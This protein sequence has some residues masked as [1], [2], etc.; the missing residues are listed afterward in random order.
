[1]GAV[2]QRAQPSRRPSP[3]ESRRPGSRRHSAWTA[4]AAAHDLAARGV[5]VVALLTAAGAA[6]LEIALTGRLGWFFD[7]VFVLVSATNALAAA[8]EALYAPTVAPP[9]VLVAVIVVVAIVQPDALDEPGT[10]PDASLVQLVV[11]A[12][13]HH[14]LALVLGLGSALAIVGW[15]RTAP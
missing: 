6:W 8:R 3:P 14:A 1:M 15:R 12:V 13:V 7:V 9:L 5:V 10:P 4:R 2:Q 11:V